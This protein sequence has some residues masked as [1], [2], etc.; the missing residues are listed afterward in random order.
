MTALDG[1]P[2]HS[3]LSGEIKPGSGREPGHP[4]GDGPAE[5]RLA[6]D[7]DVFY[8][9]HYHRV[10]GLGYAL[11]GDRSAAEELTQEAFVDAYHRWA[12]IGSYDDPG[13]WVRR[14][15]ANRA[16][17]RWRRLARDA[18]IVRRLRLRE[19]RSAATMGVI[20]ESG[21]AFWALVRRLPARQAQVVVLRYHDDRAIG[22]IAAL[23]QCR[24]NTVKAHLFK[25]RRTLAAALSVSPDSDVDDSDVGDGDVDARDEA[26]SA[27]NEE[28]R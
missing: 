26:Q 6:A 11:C 17:S 20:D 27:T 16:V 14:V 7:F 15:V 4:T 10:V 24:E 5:I 19:E 3:V 13:Q 12:T 25:A 21:E 22:E 8:A 28:G 23:L 9:A 1:A 18:S 2:R